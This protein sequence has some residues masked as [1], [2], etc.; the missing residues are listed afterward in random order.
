MGILGT[1]S[2]RRIVCSLSMEPVSS[3]PSRKTLI[4]SC[5]VKSRTTAKIQAQKTKGKK[6]KLMYLSNLN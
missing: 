2:E 6:L 1:N 3:V 5:I 4:K